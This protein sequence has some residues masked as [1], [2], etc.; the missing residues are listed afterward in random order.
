MRAQIC[1]D[2]F[3]YATV[4]LIVPIHPRGAAIPQNLHGFLGALWAG[5]DKD[6]LAI[7]IEIYGVGL[8]RVG[9]QVIIGKMGFKGLNN[10]VL[11]VLGPLQR[12]M[13]L[14]ICPKTP[15]EPS[16]GAKTATDVAR[17]FRHDGL[18]VNSIFKSR[19]SQSIDGFVRDPGRCRIFQRWSSFLRPQCSNTCGS[20]ESGI[21]RQSWQEDF[22]SLKKTA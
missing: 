18:I 9:R 16:P 11:G 17:L 19:A 8:D 10:C 7:V 21:G 5:L 14:N 6:E 13:G 1:G 22:Y 12:Q 3:L 2:L 15:P 4:L 20:G